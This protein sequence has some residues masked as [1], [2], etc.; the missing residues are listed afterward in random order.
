MVGSGGI[1]ADPERMARA[2][3]SSGRQATHVTFSS[4]L[5]THHV[6]RIDFLKIDIEGSEYALL[7]EDSEWL[8]CGQDCDGSS[9]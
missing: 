5:E 3:H 2:S 6:T 1:L 9:F 7:T 4:L 8:K